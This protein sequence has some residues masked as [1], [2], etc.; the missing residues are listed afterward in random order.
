ML[1]S[2]D[3]MKMMT[4]KD[5]DTSTINYILFKGDINF[6]ESNTRKE[7]C[8]TY[9]IEGTSNKKDIALIVENC[10]TIATL[11]EIKWID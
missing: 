9:F 7:P 6:S 10:D 8:G 11:K 2:D 1:Y 5:I 4:N 3:V